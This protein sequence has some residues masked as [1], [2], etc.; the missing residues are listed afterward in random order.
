MAKFTKEEVLNMSSDL[1]N[2]VSCQ[3]LKRRFNAGVFNRNNR[4]YVDEEGKHWSGRNC[5]Q[6]HVEKI[7]LN[8]RNLRAKKS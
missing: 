2:C 7:R 4:R 1:V 5:P 6:C 8:M 3:Q